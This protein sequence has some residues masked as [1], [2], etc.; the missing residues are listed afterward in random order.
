MAGLQTA[1]IGPA[2]TGLAAS[3]PAGGP[4]AATMATVASAG[5]AFAACSSPTLYQLPNG[6]CA[7]VPL[8]EGMRWGELQAGWLSF[9]DGKSLHFQQARC[10]VAS[11]PSC[12]KQST[13]EREPDRIGRETQSTGHDSQ[14]M[15]PQLARPVHLSAARCTLQILVGDLLGGHRGQRTAGRTVHGRRWHRRLLCKCPCRK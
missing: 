11:C 10:S 3:T 6:T 7:A 15:G 9:D 1:P 5:Q 14:S 8:S 2:L 12:F 4:A 13:A